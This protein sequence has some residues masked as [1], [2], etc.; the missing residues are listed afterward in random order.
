[1]RGGGGLWGGGG[2][3]RGGGMKKDCYVSPRQLG[4]VG[5]PGNA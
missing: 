4:R 3:G 5:F 2:G 1:M